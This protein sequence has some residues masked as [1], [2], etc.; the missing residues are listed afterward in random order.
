MT[1][2]H[3]RLTAATILIVLLGRAS[4]NIIAP[5]T[6]AFVTHGVRLE[7]VRIPA[8]RFVMGSST[9]DSNEQPVH[10]VRI[11]YDFHIG[12]TEVTVRQFRAF[13]EATGYVT[14]GEKAGSGS[15]RRGEEDWHSEIG[16]DWRDTIFLQSDDDPATF[17]SWNDAMAFC[18]WLSS[19][20][21]RE[22][23][24]PSEAEWEYACRAGTTG[25]YT[26]ELNAMGWHRYNS[27]R[28]TQPNAWGLY[29]MHGNVWEW[30]L[31]VFAL[32]YEDAPTDGSPRRQADRDYGVVSR[33]GSFI[34]PPGWLAS[35]GRMAS[36]RKCS[37]YNNGFRLV[38]VV[39]K[40]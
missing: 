37:H 20:C 18:R 30:C 7:L 32:N 12:R 11:D 2:E 9:G 1:S 28:R 40:P 31:D 21:A 13:V 10:E 4:A 14:D 36:F 6:K 26:G 35:P 8:G 34:N 16:V 23:R 3:T 24:L 15:V 19:E 25:N 27:G 38:L 39:K 17:I 5:E 33:G 22:I 29:D